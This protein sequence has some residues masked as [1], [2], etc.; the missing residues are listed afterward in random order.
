LEDGGKF[1]LPEQM[2]VSLDSQTLETFGD[3]LFQGVGVIGWPISQNA[4]EGQ[5]LKKQPL[6]RRTTKRHR[7]LKQPRKQRRQ[8]GSLPICR[9]KRT[10]NTPGVI[11]S[12]IESFGDAIKISPV[13]ELNEPNKY[14]RG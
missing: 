1:F 5:M 11:K 12:V 4:V 2:S 9:A 3:G 10:R 14:L 6:F 7:G 8:Y 13:Q